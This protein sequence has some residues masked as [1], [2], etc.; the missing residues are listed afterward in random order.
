MCVES[1]KEEVVVVLFH[2]R[3]SIFFPLYIY[4]LVYKSIQ[5]RNVCLSASSPSSCFLSSSFY[6]FIYSVRR[7]FALQFLLFQHNHWKLY[8]LQ[9][10]L[11]NV[12]K[13]SRILCQI[14]FTFSSMI[15][16]THTVRVQEVSKTKYTC[17]CVTF[18]FF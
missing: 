5:R 12:N 1:S 17:L 3:R 16:M 14:L 7:R 8:N 18:F 13:D 10:W 6:F 4:T 15:T 9:D 11:L 2:S